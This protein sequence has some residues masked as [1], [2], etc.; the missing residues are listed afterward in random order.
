VS[1]RHDPLAN[2]KLTGYGRPGFAARYDACRP[3]PPAALVDVLLPL[4]RIEHPTLVVDLGSGTGLSTALWAKR[5]REVIG[6]EPLDEMRQVA[7][8]THGTPNVRFQA[9]VAQSTGVPE[10]A[11]DIVTCAQSLHH[12]E[13]E[14][15]LTEVERILRPGGVFAV[16]DYDVPPVVDRDAE[17]AF[18][19][20]MDRVLALRQQHGISSD[21]QRWKKEEH[22]ARLE[23]RGFRYTRELSLH[24][25]EPCTAERWVDFALSIAIVPPVLDLGVSA[26]ELGLDAFRRAAARAFRDRELLWHVS[27]RVRVAIK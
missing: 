7:E 23:R 21:Q 17:E 10:G 5:A 26:D 18:F 1:A 27:Y 13:P 12:M 25:R 24:Q 20:F 9:G 16:Y 22:G 8:A 3:R 14:S 19:A 6:I 15:T 4:A 2:A 11:A